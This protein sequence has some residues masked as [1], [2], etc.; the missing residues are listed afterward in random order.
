[1]IAGSALVS[2][3]SCSWGCVVSVHV[4]RVLMLG[5]GRLMSTDRVI[6]STWLFDSSSMVDGWWYRDLHTLCSLTCIHPHASIPDSSILSLLIFPSHRGLGQSLCHCLWLHIY[7]N[8]RSI[9]CPPNLMSRYILQ[10][11][12]CSE[13][14][15]FFL[16]AEFQGHLSEVL[17]AAAVHF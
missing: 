6:L 10:C 4:P 16:A 14:F 15:F 11:F 7:A 13:D 9:L 12:A 2:R 17:I 3:T 1:M 8:L 5:K